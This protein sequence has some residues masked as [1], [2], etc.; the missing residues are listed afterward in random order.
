[1]TTTPSATDWY[2]AASADI[3]VRRAELLARIRE[4]MARRAVLEVETPALS[5]AGATD[6]NILSL[7]TAVH[8]PGG[9]DPV[10]V[11]LHTSPEFAMKRLLASGS[12]P[13]YQ[14][15]RVFRDQEAGR[16]HQPEFTMLEWYRPG[17]DQHRLMDEVTE[18]LGE[19][20]LTVTRRMTYAE[21]FQEAIGLDVHGADI[22]CLVRRAAEFGFLTDPPQRDALIDCLF[23]QE[24][25]PG[26]GR[27]GG[28][29]VYDFPASQAALARIR[30]GSPPLAER[31]EL[32]IG[33]MEIANGFHELA[34]AAEQQRRFESDNARRRSRGLPEIPVDRLLLAALAGG[35]PDCSG[36]AIG[37]DRLLMI[38][39]GTDRIGDVLAFPFDRA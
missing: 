27:D 9:G 15:A 37:L 3:L 5:H 23:S 30:P 11:Y 16:L 13:I 18:L 20:D 7:T 24:V 17:F 10:Q 1:V 35:L 26:L 29:F 22:H 6:P 12:G 8:P 28:V 21:A 25:A 34:D 19:L 4:F 2:P 33:G 14:I 38:L 31:F 36:V 32:F 39:L